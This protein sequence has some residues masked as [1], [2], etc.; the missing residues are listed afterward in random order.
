[1]PILE[2]PSCDI[3]GVYEARRCRICQRWTCFECVQI[4]NDNK[5]EHKLRELGEHKPLW[6]ETTSESD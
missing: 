1:M 5:C 6:I 3:C 4:F 2:M